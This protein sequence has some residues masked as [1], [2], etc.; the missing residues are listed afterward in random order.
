MRGPFPL[1]PLPI[2]MHVPSG[3]RGVFCLGKKTGEVSL[4][5]R[6]DKD[7]R[8]ALKSFQ[9]KYPVFWFETAMSADECFIIQCRTYHKYLE[10]DTLDDRLHPVP[11]KQGLKC[12]VCGA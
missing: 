8:T 9:G 2:G 1:Q 7:L 5:G 12:P 3:M 10:Q 6:A 11:D 4:V